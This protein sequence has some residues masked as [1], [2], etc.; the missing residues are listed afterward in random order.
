M[1]VTEIHKLSQ[2]ETESSDQVDAQTN[3]NQQH[4]QD[5]LPEE[6]K[7]TQSSAASAS[8]DIVLDDS[9]S[10]HNPESEADYPITQEGFEDAQ[11]SF[12]DTDFIST[13]TILPPYPLP[14]NRHETEQSQHHQI[15]DRTHPEQQQ[16][17]KSKFSSTSLDALRDPHNNSNTSINKLAINHNPNKYNLD[18]FKQFDSS[19][20]RNKIPIFENK[21]L[22]PNALFTGVQESGKSRF[23]IKVELKNVDLINSIVT[24]FLQ[25]SGLTDDHSE[26]VTCFK[27][28]I[29]NNPLH[30]YQWTSP[31]KKSYSDLKL[32]N[33]SF[34]TENKQWGSFVKNDFEH[35]KKLTNSSD[36]TDSQL[37][38]RLIRIQQGHEDNQFIYMR[39]KEEFLLPDSRIKQISGA[40]FEGFYYIVL[41]IGGY[42]SSDNQDVF[43]NSINPGSICGLYYHKSSEKFQSLLLRY[44]EN[45]GVAN[46]FEFV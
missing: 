3:S 40:S 19:N 23:H 34:I 32:K 41:N 4:Q 8:S 37:Q 26:I 31:D 17:P 5:P 30:K 28:E 7:L 43:S 39:W 24:G 27:G 20:P 36:L 16:S 14:T 9:S 11:S 13:S 46:T 15:R 2:H 10:L 29:I 12:G 21:Y 6:L 45:H 18:Y 1:P 44:V 33:Y 25:I 35:W 22:H 42:D 38:Q